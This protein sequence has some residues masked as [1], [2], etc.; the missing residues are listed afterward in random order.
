MAVVETNYRGGPMYMHDWCVVYLLL[1]VAYRL[2]ATGRAVSNMA[3][4]GITTGYNFIT[5]SI[6]E[7]EEARHGPASFKLAHSLCHEN[8]EP[9]KG[10]ERF[11]P[12]S[13][14]QPCLFACRLLIY[15]V[16]NWGPA[17][18]LDPGVIA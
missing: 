1:R 16:V 3:A 10:S 2:E 17:L 8:K 9:E 15:P 6:T 5:E 18:L 13:H 12:T 14:R 11:A 4:I 7:N